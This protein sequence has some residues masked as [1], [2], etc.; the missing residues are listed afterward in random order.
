M[1]IAPQLVHLI[2]A[3]GHSISGRAQWVRLNGLPS[4]NVSILNLYAPATGPRDRIELWEEL[5]HTLPRDCKWI[6]GGDW[7][8]VEYRGDKSS[9]CGRVVIDSERLAFNQITSALQ[10]EDNFSA[11]NQIKFSWDN[12]RRNG[13]RVLARLDRIYSFQSTE[14]LRTIA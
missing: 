9:S 7:N 4:G 12:R 10:V 13:I 8:F 3:K 5:L 1:W 2:G 14:A 11:S 6:L